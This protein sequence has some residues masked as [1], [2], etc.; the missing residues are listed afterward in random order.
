MNGPLAGVRIVDLGGGQA[1]AL[2]ALLLA[3]AGASVTKLDDAGAEGILSPTEDRLWNRLKVRM[4]IDSRTAAGRSEIETALGPADILI[5]DRVPDEARAA[6]ID[7]DTLDARFPNLIHAAIGGWP[8][9]HPKEDTPVRDVLALAEAGLL[10]EQA[11]LKRDGPVYLRFPLGSNHAAYLAA[12]GALARL[13]ARHQTGCGGR[14]YTSLVQGALIPMMMYWSRAER[15]TR[16]VA[17]GMPKINSPATLFECSDGLWIHTMGQVTLAAPVREALKAMPLEEREK[18]NVKYANANHKYL[19]DW[20]AIEVI[21]KT[22]PRDFWLNELWAA[23]VPVQPVLRMGEIYSD[24]QAA[25]NG[26]FVDVDVPGL[27]VTRQPGAPFQIEAKTGDPAK[28][29]RD[30]RDIRF[31]LAGI[32]VLDLGNFLAGPLG[33]MLLG[34]LGADVIKLEAT[35]GDPLRPVEWAF[36]GCQRNK[37]DIAVQLKDEKGREVMHQLVRWADVLHHNQRLPAA[38]RLGFG[39]EA[40]QR[41]NPKLTY[42]HVSSYGSKGARKDWPGFDQLFQAASGWEYEG[43]GEGN[44]PIWYRFGMLDHL[45]ALASVMATLLALFRRDQSGLG[46]LVGASLLGA[47]LVTSETFVLPDGTLAP[48]RKLDSEQLGVSPVERIYLCRDGWLAVSARSPESSLDTLAAI[49][50]TI[51]IAPLLTELTVAQAQA[52]FAGSDIAATE[53]RLDN[54]DA[55]FDDQANRDIGLIATFDHPVYGK[56]E[57][58]GA[59]WDFGQLAVRLDRAPPL[60]GQHTTEILTELG[61]DQGTQEALSAAC[62]VAGTAPVVHPLAQAL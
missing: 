34:D 45:G 17:N 8:A 32:K 7:A 51:E 59:L 26:Y 49:F 22:R 6:G 44:P 58:I 55:F 54:K 20:G 48:Y 27:G 14:V 61:Y 10:D 25:A 11:A 9:G 1:A 23:D 31:P 13:Y 57:H 53:V 5:H 42:C 3:Q 19:E 4:A 18:Y 36:N 50:G 39:Y 56:F 28:A 46:E 60:L 52:R 16:S 29:A 15:P 38:E 37:R 2:A 40:T 43:A 47:G 62:I 33:A 35:S 24:K 41:I 21:F 12:I 30:N